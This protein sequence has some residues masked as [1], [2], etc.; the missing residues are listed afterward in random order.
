MGWQAVTLAQAQA[1]LQA[2]WEG[3]PFWTAGESIT[4]LNE[5]IRVWNLLTGMW[6]KRVVVAT[7]AGSPWV[8]LPSTLVYGAKVNFISTPLI[9]SSRSDLDNFQ[10]GWEAET[11]ASGGSVPSSPMLWAP[12][13]L[14][15]LAIWPADAVGGQSLVID[16]VRS[17]PVLVNPTDY[18]DIG[19]HELDSI[20]GFALH[21]AAFKLGSPIF[22]GTF[23]LRAAFL[24][25]AADLNTRLTASSY[26][27]KLLGLDTARY[28]RPFRAPDPI[29][30]AKQT[31]AGGN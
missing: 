17:T 2:K 15:L 6:R 8:P 23:P 31:P 30:Q 16:G 12:A 19:E 21:I 7:P 18:I 26:F 25:N 5:A 14:T 9:P 11:T 24:A 29:D 3:V 4:A 1:Q 20:L 27:R 28:S 10:I 13:G 22:P